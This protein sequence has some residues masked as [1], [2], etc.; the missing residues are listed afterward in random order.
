MCAMCVFM[1]MLL[2]HSPLIDMA[3]NEPKSEVFS[4]NLLIIHGGI[5]GQET[6]T[7]TYRIKP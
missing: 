4:K 5:E 7:S 2:L 1:C 3:K 6:T